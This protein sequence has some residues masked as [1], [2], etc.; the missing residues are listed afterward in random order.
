MSQQEVI[1]ADY[2]KGDPMTID[3]TSTLDRLDWPDD[4]NETPGWL[5]AGRLIEARYGFW[6]SHLSG[7]I[8]SV[9]DGS[10]L[11]VSERI[12]R[13]TLL[14]IVQALERTGEAQMVYN[15]ELCRLG[16]AD[17]DAATRREA[18]ALLAA[19]ETEFEWRR[20]WTPPPVPPPWKGLT[21][22]ALVEWQVARRPVPPDARA[23]TAT[24]LPAGSLGLHS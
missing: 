4:P 2:L 6:N 1:P 21:G 24:P 14:R 19:A 8:G 16:N 20:E 9:A 11:L 13:D 18:E 5:W 17:H 3:T 22:R 15:G 23:L 7:A 12:R 10:L